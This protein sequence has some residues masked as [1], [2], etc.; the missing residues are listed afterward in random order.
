MTEAAPVESAQPKPFAKAIGVLLLLIVVAG[1]AMVWWISHR[2]HPAIDQAK[3]F[4]DDLIA[5]NLPA[6]QA[7][8]TTDVD[9]DAMAR[10]ADPKTGKMKFW[11]KMDDPSF[12]VAER[13][14]RA[15]V[16]GTLTFEK[17]SKT[18]Q[19]TLMKQPDGTYKITAYGFN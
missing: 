13:G 9:F 16:D 5:G 11:G 19:A 6:A 1:G 4:I 2:S 8:C 3:A 17:L 7:R 12:I 15:D 10:L 14:E 18:F